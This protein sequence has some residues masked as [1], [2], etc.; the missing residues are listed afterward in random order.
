MGEMGCC[1]F[2]R[3]PSSHGYHALMAADNDDMSPRGAATSPPAV[4]VLVGKDRREFL[5]DPFVLAREPFRE[6]IEM[7]TKDQKGLVSSKTDAIF[8]DVDA[9]LFE[10][11]LWSVYNDFS[12][13]SCSSS[14]SS[15]SSSYSSSLLLLNL[16]EIIEFYSQDS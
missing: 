10:H 12:S 1:T 14:S 15:S 11:M 6:L 13:N 3:W 16:K 9:I 8:I 2:L 4:Q 7:A 5:V